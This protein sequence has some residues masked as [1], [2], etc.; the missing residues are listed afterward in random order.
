MSK[1]KSRGAKTL[2]D[3]KL[4]ATIEEQS[5]ELRLLREEVAEWRKKYEQGELRDI[6]FTNSERELQP[7]YTPLS[8]TSKPSRSP[9]TQ[10]PH[11]P[12]KMGASSTLSTKTFRQIDRSAVIQ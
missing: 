11:K 3:E 7:I 2:A 4:I 10:T 6:A 9:Q 8:S 1:L 12:Q 5:A